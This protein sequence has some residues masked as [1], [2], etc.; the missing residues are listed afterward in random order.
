MKG[1]PKKKGN[2]HYYDYLPS[3]KLDV[4][5]FE[6]DASHTGIKTVLAAPE[7]VETIDPKINKS[8]RT[9]FI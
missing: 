2:K 4:P 3:N 7:Q 9:T 8:G 6:D 5:L 1:D